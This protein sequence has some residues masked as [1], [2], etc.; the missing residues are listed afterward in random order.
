[1]STPLAAPIP[2]PTIT[3]VGVARPRAQGQAITSV[4]MR[5]RSANR[6]RPMHKAKGWPLVRHPGHP[7]AQGSQ[8]VLWPSG[9]QSSGRTLYAST[10]QMTK[11]S[12][13]IPTTIGTKTPEILSATA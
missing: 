13:A 1:M 10:S 11:D 5:N 2:V 3:A 6:K 7:E 12:R 4:V 9:I 8:D